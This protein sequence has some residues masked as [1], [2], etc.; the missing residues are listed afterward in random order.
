M[1][2]TI[3]YAAFLLLSMVSSTF[4][5]QSKPAETKPATQTLPK[6]D[7][8]KDK[9]SK[10]QQSAAPAPAQAQAATLTVDASML[11][12]LRARGI[13]PAVMSGRVTE[14]A[15]DPKEEATFYLA[16]G[17]AG[18]M[19]T[20]NNGATF[21]D[22][23]SKEAVA[24]VGAVAVAPSDGKIVY[25]GT[26]EANDRNSVSWG[27]GIYRSADGGDT[28][29][30]MGLKDSRVIARI[31]V[32]PTDPNTVWVAAT[33]NVWQPGGERGIYKTT[34]GG[35]NWKQ[36]LAPQAP[37]NQKV[38][39][40]DLVIDPSNPNN[41]YAAMYAR[42][43]TPWSFNAG[44]AYTDGKD[45]GGIFKSTDGGNTWRKLEK[46]LPLNTGRIGLAVYAKDPKIVYA[47]VYSV[48]SGGN[49]GLMEVKNRTGGVFRSEDGGE[50]WTRTNGLNPRPFYFSQI[51]VAPDNDK[52]IYVLGFSL[53]ISEDG[54]KTFRED[55]F[56]KVHPDLHALAIDPRNP[57][58]M[59][60]GTDGGAYQT[61]D[62]G[63]T[64]DHLN[65]FAAGQFYRI[66]YDMST[67]YRVCGG[68]Q[69]NL[70]WVGPSRTFTKEGILNQDWINIGGG[71][72]FYCIFDQDEPHL[73]YTESQEGYV[74]RYDLRNGQTKDLR[75]Q[76][77]EGQRHYRFHWNSP[78]IASR[79]KKDTMFLAGNRVFRLTGKGE[80]FQPISPDLSGQES[81]KNTTAG[82]G[83]EN[84]GVV[85]SLAES[86]VKAGLLWAATDDGKVWIT[87]DEGAN[88]TDLSA[89]L[90]AAVKGQW[91][92]RVEASWKD[93]NVAYL[94]VPAYR[95]GNF[96][97]LAYRTGDGGKSWQS[98]ASNLP[99]DGPVK[100]VREDPV[101][102]DLLFAGTEFGLFVSLDRGGSWTKFGDMPTVAVDDLQIHTRDRD[103]IIATHGRSIY[104]SDD[105]RPLQEMTA[106]TMSKELVLFQ[107][108]DGFARPIEDG[109]A[110]WNGKAIFRGA[111]PPPGVLISFFVKSFS[112][113]P[114][115]IT[116]KNAL[117]Q[118][119]AKLTAPGTAGLNRVAW[120]LKPTK[121]L[122]AEYGGEGAKFVR[123][124]EYTI[125]I[126]QGKNKDTKKIKVVVAPGVETR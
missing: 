89:N 37:Y 91:I 109:F 18:V 30:N 34:D 99:A 124:G 100:V 121:D 20:S 57:K 4:A 94:A 58:R 14:L 29:T 118:P 9:K 52:K 85:Y 25:V 110:D 47:L 113:D 46:G 114:V 115:R 120:D 119:I 73:V 51:R 116:I 68:L 75:P 62:G 41:L 38:G 35:Q 74:H 48:D 5:Q 11:K 105:I 88:W 78:L 76:P 97:P 45:V 82:S 66:N 56:E 103:L 90:P 92:S 24:A 117:D 59:L 86:P 102:P 122:I 10:S 28:W 26:G 40:G 33:G 98:I 67:P 111:N 95:S 42:Q 1:R 32:H 84:Y 93:A 107:P 55:L 72:G 106:E 101:N 36:V 125:T 44:P 69:D 3:F 8:K 39:G 54:G 61:Y 50:T 104:I 21:A 70:N 65:R 126:T 60:L 15:F 13:G 108:K 19:K 81:E 6:A 87:Q 79:H 31:V 22:I 80:Q 63:S 64:W 17:T 2:K 27:N 112:G 77:E 123:E 7:P 49:R 83:A 96:A 53:H 12:A 43:R 71:D 16:L 23:F